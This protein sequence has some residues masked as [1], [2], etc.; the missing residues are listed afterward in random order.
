MASAQL[1]SVDAL[2][3]FR[4]ALI[5]FAEESHETMVGLDMELQRGLQ[6]MLDTQPRF[7]KSEEKRLYDLVLQAKADLSR[8]RGMAMKGETPACTE[9][10]HALERATAQLR[11]A[12]EK[13][14]ITQRWGRIIQHDAHEFQGRANQFT[15]LLEGDLPRAISLLDRAIAAVEAYLEAP[16]GGSSGRVATSAA[17][18]PPSAEADDASR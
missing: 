6:W 7:W 15:S 1:T 13:S 12:E 2:R 8:A 14:K 17:E 18:A 9:Q 10:K 11:H 4:A 3:R 5:A 16:S